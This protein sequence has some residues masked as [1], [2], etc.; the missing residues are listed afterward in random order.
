[1]TTRPD[2][3]QLTQELVR[4]PSVNPQADYDADPALLGEARVASYV[5]DLLAAAGLRPFVQ[6]TSLAGRDNVGA[7]LQVNERF[8][9]LLLQAHMDTVGIAGRT[10][11]LEPVVRDGA[12][13]GRGSCDDKGG[14][15]AML[16][17]FMIAA[18]DRR[19]L[20]H[21]VILMAVVDEEIG[22]AGAEAL[23]AQEP[24]RDADYAVVAEPTGCRIVQ[25]GKGVAR[26]T[27]EMR[28]QSAHSSEPQEGINAIYRMAHLLGAIE[29]YGQELASYEDGLLGRETISVGTIAGGTSV[30]IVPDTCRISVDRRLTRLFD[31]CKAQD[32]LHAFLQ[33]EIDFSFCFSPLSCTLNAALVPTDHPLI[34]LARSTCRQ[35]GLGDEPTIVSYGSDAL[36]M[37][38]AGL[39]AILFGPGDIAFAHRP[40]ERVPLG[41]LATARDFYLHLMCSASPRRR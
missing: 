17:A 20:R 40:E 41:Q 22:G 15:A 39:P 1:M 25:G 7:V 13:W 8:P 12:L 37:C 21:N 32:E 35:M 33:H 3:V 10:E 18:A 6:S 14:L 27:I 11:L 4:L 28:G 38:A 2:V 30:N 26:W 36:R 19:A 16:A 23:L 34:E 31:G 24:T 9:T 5:Y 29:R